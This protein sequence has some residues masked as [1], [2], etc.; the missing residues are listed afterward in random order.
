VQSQSARAAQL[1]LSLLELRDARLKSVKSEQG[2]DFGRDELEYVFGTN[3]I[4][5][6]D[7]YD[8]IELSAPSRH[9]IVV[10]G[11]HFF[12]VQWDGEQLPLVAELQDIFREVHLRVVEHSES[13]KIVSLGILSGGERDAWGRQRIELMA[14]ADGREILHWLD[15]AIFL[16]SLCEESGQELDTLLGRPMDSLHLM[17]LWQDKALQVEVFKGGSAALV[18]DSFLVSPALGV[19]LAEAL[20]H[21][22]GELVGKSHGLVKVCDNDRESRVRAHPLIL[23]EGSVKVEAWLSEWSGRNLHQ[24]MPFRSQCLRFENL[25][26]ETLI[27]RNIADEVCL[28]ILI[29]IAFRVVMG[30]YPWGFCY[31]LALV[32]DEGTRWHCSNLNGPNFQKIFDALIFS[33]ELQE[34]VLALTSLNEILESQFSLFDESAE[35]W[36][37]WQ[38]LLA[39]LNDGNLGDRATAYQEA[40]TVLKNEAELRWLVSPEVNIF[41]SHPSRAIAAIEFPP[42]GELPGFSVS[43]CVYPKFFQVDVL[44]CGWSEEG[45]NQVTEM[46]GKSANL[47]HRCLTFRG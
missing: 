36:T 6:C 26:Q 45:F 39:H 23:R 1:S 7:W 9:F 38:L 3:R 4:P 15:S 33:K 20:V 25:G 22:S 8:G 5:L 27:H 17:N 37:A 40:Q 43:G 30:R 19:A 11:G 35:T 2:K 16:I 24:Q 34:K 46:L 21:R 29:G 13:T 31:W 32:G 10:T 18:L 44:A 47:L 28:S 12:V 42:P 14:M 41:A